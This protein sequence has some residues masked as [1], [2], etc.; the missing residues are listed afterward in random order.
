MADLVTL[1]NSDDPIS[2]MVLF[3]TELTS[4]SVVSMHCALCKSMNRKHVETM[5][6]N[7]QALAEIMRYLQEKNDP[8][9]MPTIRHHMKEHY[10][11]LEQV[12]FMMDYCDRLEELRRKRRS[13]EKDLDTLIDIG[14]LEMTRIISMPVGSDINKERMRSELMQKTMHGIRE[15]IESRNDMES[16]DQ[17]VKA[18]EMNFAKAWKQCIDAAPPEQKA[19]FAQALRE[20]QK[21]MGEQS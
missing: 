20:F 21:S 17:A 10:R 2:K 1:E 18:M 4:G 16:K 9:A 12:A 19:L 15:T 6:D 14:F 5:Y 13:R 8:V 7:G 11:S 3:S